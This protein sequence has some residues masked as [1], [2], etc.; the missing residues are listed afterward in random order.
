M[1]AVHLQLPVYETANIELKTNFLTPQKRRSLKAKEF[2][3]AEQRSE[4]VER[5]IADWEEKNLGHRMVSHCTTGRDEQERYRPGQQQ[6][7]SSGSG[8]AGQED[9]DWKNHRGFQF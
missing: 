3:L 2:Q 7:S 8:V 1:R 4:E 6:D 9:L 5:M